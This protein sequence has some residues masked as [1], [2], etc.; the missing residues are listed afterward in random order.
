MM[1]HVKKVGLMTIAKDA[2]KGVR[3]L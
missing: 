2:L 3:A 1:K